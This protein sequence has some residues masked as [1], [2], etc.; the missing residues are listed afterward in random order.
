MKTSLYIPGNSILHRLDPRTKMAMI[1]FSII[2][3]FTY[4]NPV[5]SLILVL[6]MSAALI[7]A[8]GKA[9]FKNAF[10]QMIPVLILTV[11]ILH[12][13]ANP[14]GVTPI[15]IG[16]TIIRVPFFDEMKWEGLY[17][18][19]V[20]AL[21]IT[22]VYICSLILILTTTPEGLVSSI[23]KMGI[24]FNYASMFGMSL[25]MIPILQEEAAIIV[26]AQRAR[27]LRE[28]NFLEKVQ[29]LIPLFVP[30]AVGAMQQAETTAMV[31]EARG[32]GAPVKR[33]EL[34]PIK[35]KWI[36]YL[37]LFVGLAI[38]V[39]LLIFRITQ[40]DINWIDSVR[41][42]PGLFWPVQH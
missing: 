7:I 16:K 30:L 8:V 27:A 19:T 1:V 37:L 40:G 22:S 5:A 26:Q 36:D 10:V 35:F 4:F 31:L 25:Q 34:H 33:T 21:R 11:V 24:P 28:N 3:A 41:S 2:M 42:V 29:S 20:Y 14:V 39:S 32:F 18:G 15:Q 12:A 17:F 38:T 23:V 6:V 9:F 13:F